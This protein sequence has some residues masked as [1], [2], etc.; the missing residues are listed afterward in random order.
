M[1]KLTKLLI[2]IFLSILSC[3]C[4][5]GCKKDD[6]PEFVRQRVKRR[7]EID[8]P[9]NAE[10]VYCFYESHFQSYTQYACFKFEETPSELLEN[11]S[12]TEGRNQEIET[13]FN[14]SFDHWLIDSVPDEYRANFEESYSCVKKGTTFL[15]FHP[16]TLT[17]TV[18][19][20]GL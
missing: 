4:F 14:D 20:T 8:I 18:Y 3:C 6:D 15:V 12:F 10:I 11:N 9:E 1:K 19:I 2:A 7:T 16:N 5:F 17:L 13:D